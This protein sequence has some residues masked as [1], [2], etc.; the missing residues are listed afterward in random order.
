MNILANC[1]HKR[2][3]RGCLEV[4]ESAIKLSLPLDDMLYLLFCYYQS[5]KS[6]FLSDEE[7][8]KYAR[9]VT[10]DEIMEE[11]LVARDI[12]T[13]RMNKELMEFEGHLSVWRKD[14]VN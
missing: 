13:M 14:A 9:S 11:L 8:N 12:M 1:I 7:F 10:F 2:Y 5:F 3:K 4:L 6:P